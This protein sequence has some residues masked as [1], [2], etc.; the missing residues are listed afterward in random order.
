MIVDISHIWTTVIDGDSKNSASLF[1]NSDLEID[2]LKLYEDLEADVICPIGGS[3]IKNP[4]MLN[5]H[6][7]EKELLMSWLY[8]KK[9]DPLTNLPVTNNDLNTDIPYKLLRKRDIR[10]IN[11]K[12]YNVE[13]N[14][15]TIDFET[16]KIMFHI[17]D[18]KECIN[19]CLDQILSYKIQGAYY[20]CRSLE[21]ILQSKIH[22]KPS[23]IYIMKSNLATTLE[24]YL[25]R[26]FKPECN[27]PIIQDNFNI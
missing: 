17:K 18:T 19:V 26:Y 24:K 6:C 22:A 23:T 5:G 3:V 9:T 10:Y 13:I 25:N 20:T 4:I 8:I 14:R 16:K 12:Q 15:V 2:N 27:G 7:Y 11:K 21:I 1:L